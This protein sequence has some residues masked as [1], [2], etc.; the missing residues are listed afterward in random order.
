MIEE[1]YKHKKIIDSNSNLSHKEKTL[2]KKESDY[3]TSVKTYKP[4]TP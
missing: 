4:T 2:N 1:A 3:I